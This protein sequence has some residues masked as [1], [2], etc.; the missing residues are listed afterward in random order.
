MKPDNN[1]AFNT[2]NDFA[3]ETM[4]ATQRF[5]RHPDIAKDIAVKIYEQAYPGE[6]CHNDDYLEFLDDAK[7]IVELIAC[8]LNPKE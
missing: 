5:L 3:K 8:R 2:M 6:Q 4:K 1:F 7:E